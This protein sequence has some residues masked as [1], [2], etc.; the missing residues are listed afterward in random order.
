ME[1]IKFLWGYSLSFYLVFISGIVQ[2]SDLVSAEWLG[3]HIN[4]PDLV[5]VD[6]RNTEDY[7]S[8][9]IPGAINLPFE[10]LTREKDG[11]SGYIETPNNFKNVMES[12]GIKNIHKVVLYSDWS[13]L[14]SMRSYWVF[15][16]YG[17]TDKRVLNGG[18]QAWQKLFPDLSR[19]SKKLKSSKYLIEIHPEILSTKFKTFMASK[20][21]DFY[22]VDARDENQYNGET[23]LSNRKGHIP[24]AKNL[25]WYELVNNRDNA[26][27]YDR[28]NRVSRMSDIKTIKDKLS[29][30]PKDK[31]IILYCNAGQEAAVIYFSLKELGIESSI[32]DGSWFE[33]SSD[34][35]M[36]VEN[37]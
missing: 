23:S 21:K 11:I 33:W 7:D 28:I 18:I 24:N 10:R 36:P 20:S 37:K 2:A 29:V 4:D 35:K 15:D 14:E 19:T 27:Q 9:H 25:P 32:Y 22:I 3:Q 6:L 12:S 8:G 13:F 34:I 26:D 1:K 17:H 5:I 31:N 30:I 16:Y